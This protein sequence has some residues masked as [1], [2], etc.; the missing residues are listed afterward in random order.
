MKRIKLADNVYIK[1][2]DNENTY[3]KEV[4]PEVYIYLEDEEGI[5]IQD[6]I[7][8]RNAGSEYPRKYDGTVEVLVYADNM[9]EDYTHSFEIDVI[10]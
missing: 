3:D 8:V 7:I 10:N 2:D 5:C 6:L 9:T 1:I 4:G